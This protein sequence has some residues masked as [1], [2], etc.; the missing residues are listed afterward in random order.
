MEDRSWHNNL[1]IVGLKEVENE[2]WEQTEQI[3]K[4]MIL[5]K[6]EI[7]DVNIERAHRVGNTINTLPRAAVGE[8]F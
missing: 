6:I 8:V 1:R 5:E 4:S 2:T 7:D 3:L